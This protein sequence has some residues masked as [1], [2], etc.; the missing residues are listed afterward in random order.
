MKSVNS[1]D[2]ISKLFKSIESKFES[3]FLQ[4]SFNFENTNQISIFELKSENFQLKSL[5]NCAL[6]SH[7]F[8]LS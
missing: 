6:I 1:F 7:I 5:N 4:N 8:K 3:P 2:E